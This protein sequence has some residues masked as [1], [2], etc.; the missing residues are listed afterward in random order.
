MEKYMDKI[1]RYEEQWSA[2]PPVITLKSGQCE[3]FPQALDEWDRQI[4]NRSMLGQE[5]RIFP[6]EAPR[7]MVES[8]KILD[9]FGKQA[10]SGVTLEMLPPDEQARLIYHHKRRG[11]AF[12]QLNKN[13]AY[14]QQ[15]LPET[16]AG[17][18][19]RLLI[20]KPR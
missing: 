4:C 6:M 9:A 8:S 2:L 15:S 5:L 20:T 14:I 17:A 13:M 1:I 3:Y 7:E 18:R 11:D 19:A 10:A 12:S 16:P